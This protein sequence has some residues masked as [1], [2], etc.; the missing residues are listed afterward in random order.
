[1]DLFVII[2]LPADTAEQLHQLGAKGEP[3][4]AVITRL[5]NLATAKKQVRPAG[6]W[7]PEVERRDAAIPKRATQVTTKEEVHDPETNRR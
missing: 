7:P 1:M 2:Q 3:L 5:V 6:T 4:E